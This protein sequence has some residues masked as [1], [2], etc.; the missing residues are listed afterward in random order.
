MTHNR[1]TQTVKLLA[2]FPK[3]PTVV[4]NQKHLCNVLYMIRSPHTAFSSINTQR[5]LFVC[6]S[7]DSELSLSPHTSEPKRSTGCWKSV[8][9]LFNYCIF[10]LFLI[11]SLTQFLL[12]FPILHWYLA[13]YFGRKYS[14]SIYK[15]LFAWDFSQWFSINNF[16]PHVFIGPYWSG[17]YV[18]HIILTAPKELV[19]HMSHHKQE[20][21]FWEKP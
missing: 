12:W 1:Q 8:F 2:S 16:S 20:E 9:S 14:F 18:H 4:L 7:V 21:V 17:S 13:W 6:L 3:N 5:H 10:F 11:Q 15:F 19:L